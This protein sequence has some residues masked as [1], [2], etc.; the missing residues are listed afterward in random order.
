MNTL[1]ELKSILEYGGPGQPRERGRPANVV[2]PAEELAAL[3]KEL[4]HRA[5]RYLL[6][7]LKPTE[8]EQLQDDVEREVVSKAAKK[9]EE[10]LRNVLKSE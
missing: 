9:F 6:G 8:I 10:A 1:N 5:Q 2:E 4:M 7:S 3:A